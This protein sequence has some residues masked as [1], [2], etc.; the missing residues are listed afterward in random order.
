MDI[1]RVN[2]LLGQV[3]IKLESLDPENTEEGIETMSPASGGS[4]SAA[5]GR[6]AHLMAKLT[7]GRSDKNKVKATGAGKRK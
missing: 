1:S 7:T 2:D 3:R 5:N 4:V 6:L